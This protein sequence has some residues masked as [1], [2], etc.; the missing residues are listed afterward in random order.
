MR[1]F[2][3]DLHISVIADIKCILESFGIEV[4][5]WSLSGH[6]W[7]FNKAPDTVSVI[8]QTSWMKLSNDT[9]RRFHE[10]Y[11]DFLSTFDGFICGHPN[12]FAL[13][14]EKYQK[15]IYVVNTC[16][17]DIPFSFTGD[18]K[19]ISEL[20]DCF[21][22]LS[23]KGLLRIVSNNR[24]DRDYFVLGNPTIVPVLVHSLCLYTN[25]RWDPSKC[26]RR[27]FC[28][29]GQ[30]IVPSHP[31]IVK[32]KGTFQWSDLANYSGI[33]HIPYEASTMSIFEHMSS[34]I[35]LFFPTKRFLKELW[36]SGKSRFGC[37]YWREF[38]KRAPP[39]YLSSTDNHNF[40]LDRA[41]YYDIPGYYYFDSFD[42]LIRMLAVFFKDTK[43]EE[44]ER[45]LEER[46]KGVYNV[47]TELIK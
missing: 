34:G 39:E 10:V 13:L 38:A 4:I 17:Y 40:W 37:N 16:R 41:D 18:T 2:N 32:R 44:R 28:Y 14:Y 15:P 3:L 35:P 5:N 22:R 46:K 7:V 25:M 30:D 11:D 19:M 33:V 43:Y 47:W 29:S 9:I 26:Q 42:Q 24:A 27:F 6:A 20:H 23:D 36:V 21:R 31:L 1:L 12:S 8:N 45:W